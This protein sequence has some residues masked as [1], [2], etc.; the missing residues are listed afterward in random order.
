M[1]FA[2]KGWDFWDCG[3]FYEWRGMVWAQLR[4]ESRSMPLKKLN[5]M[6]AVERQPETASLVGQESALMTLESVEYVVYVVLSL[7]ISGRYS[8]LYGNPLKL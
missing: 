4:I 5:G 7:I 2:G 6:L 8:T 3:D 1:V